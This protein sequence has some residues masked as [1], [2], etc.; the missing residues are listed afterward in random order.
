MS[1]SDRTRAPR[2]AGELAEALLE[3][4]GALREVRARRLVIDWP[5][6]VGERIAAR[7]RPGAIARGVL[8]IEV[9]NAAWLQELSL[10]KDELLER[11]RGKLEGKPHIEEIALRLARRS[12]PAE[13]GPSR[14]RPARSGARRA[15]RAPDAADLEAIRR[16]VALVADPELRAIILEARR[17]MAR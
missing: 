8:W 5:E 4:C 9:A 2:R 16:E 1:R 17:R 11:I 10:L 7:T 3:R 14:S 12:G 13:D 6:I 15:A